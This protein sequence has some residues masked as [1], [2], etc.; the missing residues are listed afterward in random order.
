[1]SEMPQ[2][3]TIRLIHIQPRYL[4][5]NIIRFGVYQN[6]HQGFFGAYPSLPLFAR[7]Q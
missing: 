2:E 4:P 1:M 5:L 3:G 7:S 6:F